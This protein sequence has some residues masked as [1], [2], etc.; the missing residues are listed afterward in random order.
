MARKIAHVYKP[1]MSITE[2]EMRYAALSLSPDSGR[3]RAFFFLRDSS[4]L[5][6]LVPSEFFNHFFSG[7]KEEEN[8]LEALKENILK[9]G[10]EVRHES[11]SFTMRSESCTSVRFRG[12]IHKNLT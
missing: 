8:K 9:S 10:F 12:H 2:L 7:S 3:D 1:R 4:Q 6:K 11:V 5:E